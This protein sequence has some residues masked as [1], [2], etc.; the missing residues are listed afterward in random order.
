M[1]Q[2]FK[3]LDIGFGIANNYE[4]VVWQIKS[5]IG[6][7]GHLQNM[8]REESEMLSLEAD[9]DDWFNEFEDFMTEGTA[10]ISF[11]D[12][13]EFKE[14]FQQIRKRFV[15]EKHAFQNL[16]KKEK[17]VNEKRKRSAT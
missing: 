12:I 6:E 2:T 13:S 11:E 8:E 14:K 10:D 1:N 5:M 3:S 4:S 15:V 9:L 17:G 16:P 7:M